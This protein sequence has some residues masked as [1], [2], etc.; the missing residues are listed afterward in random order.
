M[1]LHQSIPS[2]KV[3][4][5]LTTISTHIQAPINLNFNNTQLQNTTRNLLNQLSSNNITGLLSSVLTEPEQ[6]SLYKVKPIFDSIN[7]YLESDNC[8]E[9][10]GKWKALQFISRI[11][12]LIHY[13]IFV[14][15]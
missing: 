12:I 4:P 6:V 3:L 13:Q 10:H 5:T 2:N 8:T 15:V 14:S 7:N 1:S 9:E 11:L